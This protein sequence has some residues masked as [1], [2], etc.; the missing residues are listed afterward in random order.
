MDRCYIIEDTPA[1]AVKVQK[2][3]SEEEFN[4]IRNNYCTELS[5]LRKRYS[6]KMLECIMKMRV[7]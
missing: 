4:N 3:Y 6:K 7:N 5:A 1:V 2:P